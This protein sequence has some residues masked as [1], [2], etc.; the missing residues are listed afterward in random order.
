M[1]AYALEHAKRNSAGLR[2]GEVEAI[3]AS[4]HWIYPGEIKAFRAKLRHMRNIGIP[5]GIG[6]PGK[7]KVL[8]FT[9]EQVLE[10]LISLDLQAAGWAP[11]D[12]QQI[13]SKIVKDWKLAGAEEAPDH[14]AVLSLS[15]GGNAL[16]PK[17]S[18]SMCK[19]FERASALVSQNSSRL[20][21]V[22][23]VSA[24]ARSLD[25]AL[26]KALWS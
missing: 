4:V 1:E 17:Y 19:G 10:M 5:E 26:G 14:Y 24:S 20:H 7:G 3:L 21:T 11:Y 13:V 2:Y 18:V 22:I 25:E 23:N 16:A 9:K 6:E 8:R 12:T 15:I